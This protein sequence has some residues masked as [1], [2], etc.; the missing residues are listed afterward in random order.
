MAKIL[1]VDSSEQLLDLFS[2]LLKSKGHE[3]KSALSRQELYQTLQDFT[4]DLMLLETWL[5]GDDGREICYFL[6]QHG[7]HAPIIL[8]STDFVLLDNFK[9]YEA[10]DIIEKPFDIAVLYEKVSMLLSFPVACHIKQFNF[11]SDSF[12][13]PST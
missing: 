2:L 1:A 4:P 10:D 13:K 8:M 5:S 7:F 11:V 6:K 9:K 3:V 12:I